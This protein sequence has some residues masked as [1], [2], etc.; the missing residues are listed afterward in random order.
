MNKLIK[1]SLVALLSA[2]SAYCADGTKQENL[3]EFGFDVD[4]GSWFVGW[5]QTSNGAKVITN[6]TEAL[7]VNYNIDDSM[8]VTTVLKAN[9]KTI[10]AKLEYYTTAITSVKNEEISGL[11]LGVDMLELVPNL[12][13]ELRVLRSDFKGHIKATEKSDGSVASES[14]SDGTFSTKLKI[15]DLIVYPF[16]DYVGV[17]Y[18]KYN[19]EFPQDLYLVRNS[20][21]KGTARGLANVE[22][23]GDFYTFVVDNK[24]LVKGNGVIYSLMYG[25]GKLDP[26]ASGYEKWTKTSDASFVDIL[27]GYSY[28]FKKKNSLGLGVN[29]GYRYNKI[30]TTANKKGG[31]YSLIT[32]FQTEFY[33][34]FIN[35]A[36]SY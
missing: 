22:Y 23:D 21:N 17:G 26:K 29:G 32:E 5:N 9:Y 14:P 13:V 16:N 1:L 3:K 20:D 10:S 27:L 28:K 4:V 24:R 31:E 12:G 6:K 34:P 35:V 15:D 11:N 25:K 8:A 33:G 18:R 30:E 2:T 36:I 7:N 19:Y